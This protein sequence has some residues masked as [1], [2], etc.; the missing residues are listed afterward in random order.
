MNG[1]LRSHVAFGDAVTGF[2][3]PRYLLYRGIANGLSFFPWPIC[4][5]LSAHSREME[6]L[7]GGFA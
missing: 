6:G 7:E 4:E 3:N 2:L 5:E 1:K